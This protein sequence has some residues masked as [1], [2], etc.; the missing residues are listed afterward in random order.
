MIEI[1][2]NLVYS[3]K[4]GLMAMAAVAFIAIVVWTLLRPKARIEADALLWKDDE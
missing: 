4:I 3:V 2:E 1:S